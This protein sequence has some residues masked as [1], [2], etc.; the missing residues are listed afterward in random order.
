[1]NEANCQ[2]GSRDALTALSRS[3]SLAHASGFEARRV[4]EVPLPSG[5]GTRRVSEGKIGAVPTKGWSLTDCI[6]FVVMTELALTGD[7]H[8]E[9]AGCRAF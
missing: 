1:P 2:F 9:Q 7:H 3:R 5:I 4:S 6:W 8:F